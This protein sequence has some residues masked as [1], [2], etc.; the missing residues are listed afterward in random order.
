MTKSVFPQ[1]QNCDIWITECT[2]DWHEIR[3]CRVCGL[4]LQSGEKSQGPRYNESP[5]SERFQ[6]E[7]KWS[8]HYWIKGLHY[9]ARCYA[10][11]PT[12][13]NIKRACLKIN[14]MYSALSQLGIKTQQ[15]FN[16]FVLHL[17]FTICS[18]LC[19]FLFFLGRKNVK[20]NFICS[21]M[22]HTKFANYWYR[23]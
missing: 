8:L 9:T 22:A 15:T 2:H 18:K 14:C 12:V 10:V 23:M 5:L 11:I 1:E 7:K 6:L 3:L 4:A 21:M 16:D 13:L 17:N 20:Y 19:F